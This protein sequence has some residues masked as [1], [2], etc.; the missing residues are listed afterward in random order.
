MRHSDSAEYMFRKST[1]GPEWE[2]TV[3]HAVPVTVKGK[4]DIFLMWPEWELVIIIIPL[5]LPSH[6]CNRSLPAAHDHCSTNIIQRFCGCIHYN[7]LFSVPDLQVKLAFLH[8]DEPTKVDL[9]C[10]SICALFSPTYKWFR[11]GVNAGPGRFYRGTVNSEDSYACAVEGFERFP[12]PSVC[13]STPHYSDM[14]WTTMIKNYMY[15]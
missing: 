4:L 2:S 11:N 12:S 8:S 7:Y 14:L 1:K 9:E 5:F 3:S 15:I 10:H 6:V 13:K